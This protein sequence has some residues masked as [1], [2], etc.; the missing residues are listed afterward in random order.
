MVWDVRK[1]AAQN[2]DVKGECGQGVAYRV[3]VVRETSMGGRKE[4][5]KERH[6]VMFLVPHRRIYHTRQ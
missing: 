1:P 2:V 6:T 5:R 3:R 4:T